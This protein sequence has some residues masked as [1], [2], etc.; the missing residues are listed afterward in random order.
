MV[1]GLGPELGATL[2]GIAPR[3]RCRPAHRGRRGR[4]RGE[5]PCRAGAPRRRHRGRRRCRRGRGGRRAGHRVARRLRPHDRQRRGVRSDV[6]SR[7]RA[8]WPR[9]TSPAGRTL[10]STTRSCAWSTGRTPPSRVSPRPRACWRRDDEAA[11]FAP[12]PFVWSDQY[13]VKIQCAGH[14]SGDDTVEIVDGS[15]DERR[16]VAIFGR[17][18]RLTGAVVVQ[19]PP[20]AHAVPAPHRRRCDVRRRT[21]VRAHAR[22]DRA[23]ETQGQTRANGRPRL[24]TLRFATVVASGILYFLAIGVVM[25][26]VPRYVKHKLDGGSLAVGVAVGALF[27]GAVVLRPLAGRIGDRY[28]RRLLVIG[29]AA[30]VG[31]SMLGV[32][33][34]GLDCPNSSR[35]ASSPGWAKPPSSWAPRR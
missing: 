22:D 20:A 1:R 31:V 21:G 26:A 12:I 11:A 7:R 19:S 23:R 5:R 13:D 28:G 2:G 15:L 9:A 16:F 6:G 33:A 3:P 17:A 24:I 25:P 18:G 32:R 30:I 29:G 35:R 34:R 10:R 4:L 8:S 27:V 14:V